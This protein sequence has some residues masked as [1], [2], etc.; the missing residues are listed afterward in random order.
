MD[1][2]G[3]I[4]IILSYS[5]SNNEKSSAETTENRNES[6]ADFEYLKVQ[7]KRNLVK[8][9]QSTVRPKYNFIS[10]PFTSVRQ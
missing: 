5:A 6:Q 3:L 9:N 4:L 7:W 10:L 1:K 8:A 2:F